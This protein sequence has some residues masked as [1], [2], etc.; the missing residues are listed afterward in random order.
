M[1]ILIRTQDNLVLGSFDEGV[2]LMYAPC[3]CATETSSKMYS[4]YNTSGSM[5]VGHVTLPDNYEIM[6]YNYDPETEIW[7]ENETYVL[8]QA[9]NSENAE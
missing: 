4:G 6:K 3:L 2:P 1:N 7:S 5:I 9:F 8:G